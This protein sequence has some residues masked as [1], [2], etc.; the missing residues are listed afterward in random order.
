M[1]GSVTQTHEYRVGYGEGYKDCRMKVLN[2]LSYKY[3]NDPNRPDRGSPEALAIL[4][5]VRELSELMKSE[6]N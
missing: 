6:N 5:L 4:A 3:I 2:H 1:A